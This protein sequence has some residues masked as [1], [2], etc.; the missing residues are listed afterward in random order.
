M[1]GSG[2]RT[3]KAC[4]ISILADTQHLTRKGPEQPGLTLNLSLPEQWV[5]LD[6]PQRFLP[7]LIIL[8]MDTSFERF[9]CLCE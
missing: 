6:N 4:G 1:K 7:E 5:R 2:S 8:C 3:Q 9:S